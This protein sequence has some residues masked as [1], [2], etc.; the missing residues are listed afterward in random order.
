LCGLLSAYG[1]WYNNWIYW[2]PTTLTTIAHSSTLFT[3]HYRSHY[4]FWSCYSLGSRCLAPAT[5]ADVPR[6]PDARSA[7]G[8]SERKLDHKPSYKNSCEFVSS[9]SNIPNFSS[10]FII[11]TYYTRHMSRC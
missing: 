5:I 9:G 8:D 4:I 1:V 7:G 10:G 11:F 2:T 3:D 6:P